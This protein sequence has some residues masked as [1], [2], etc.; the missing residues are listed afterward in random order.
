MIELMPLRQEYLEAVARIA[1][2]SLTEH[3]SFE[4]MQGVLCREAYC[5]Y[6]AREK[7][8]VAGFAGILLTAEDAELVTIAVSQPFR[9]RGIGQKL[10]EKMTAEAQRGGA[11]RLLLEVRESN[12]AAIRLYRKNGFK[13]LAVRKGYYRDPVENALVMEKGL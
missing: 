7:D 5:Y 12:A 1:E 10:L 8:V 3:W 13:E 9:E 6:L 4:E 2:E 11:R